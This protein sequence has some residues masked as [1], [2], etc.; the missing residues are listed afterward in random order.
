M[1]LRDVNVA[2]GYY[3]T[4][5]PSIS[6]VEQLDTQKN[7]DMVFEIAMN[8]PEIRQHIQMTQ[9][10]FTWNV[11]KEPGYKKLLLPQLQAVKK[12]APVKRRHEN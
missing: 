6:Y 11:L 4:E 8:Y 3:Q 5:L 2:E 10:S 12:S 9:S 7:V 1:A